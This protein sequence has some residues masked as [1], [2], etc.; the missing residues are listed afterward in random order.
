[1]AA[2]TGYVFGAGLNYGQILISLDD[3]FVNCYRGPDAVK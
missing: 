1:M 2:P 3:E